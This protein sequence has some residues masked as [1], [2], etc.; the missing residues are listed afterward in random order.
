PHPRPPRLRAR[1]SRSRPAGESSWTFQILHLEDDPEPRQPSGK[2]RIEVSPGKSTIR[3]SYVAFDKRA[4]WHTDSLG[5][6]RLA[7]SRPER[8]L[9]PV[10]CSLIPEG[11][12]VTARHQGLDRARLRGFMRVDQDSSHSRIRRTPDSIP[13]RVR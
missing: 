3:R 1:G 5:S 9:G 8:S 11:D 13:V 7:E 6:I 4:S 10:D 12:R 2:V